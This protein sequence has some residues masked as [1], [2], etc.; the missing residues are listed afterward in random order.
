MEQSGTGGIV[1][2]FKDTEIGPIPTDWELVL[3]TDLI[4]QEWIAVRNGFP[5]GK[6]NQDGNGLPHLRPFNIDTGGQVN[7]QTIK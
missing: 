6:H 1:V 3:I 5:C 4:R 7:L 2:A